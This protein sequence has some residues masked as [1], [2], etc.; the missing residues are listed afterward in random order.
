M[1]PATPSTRLSLLRVGDHNFMV[2]NRY[3]SQ[4]FGDFADR[5]KTTDGY[6]ESSRFM[7]GLLLGSHNSVDEN[8]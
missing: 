6:V 5:G 2:A 7:R 8:K 4:K 3:D 1:D